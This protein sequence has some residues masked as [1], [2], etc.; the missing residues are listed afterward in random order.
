MTKPVDI[1]FVDD[2]EHIRVAVS[3][4]FELAD[5]NTKCFTSSI[6]LLQYVSRDF[7]GIV[8]SDIRMPD[9]DGVELLQKVTEIDY[10]LPVIL[11][12]GHGDV[13]LAVETMK[14]GAY[15]FIEKPFNPGHLVEIVKRA[16]SKRH[17]T[18]ENRVLKANFTNQDNLEVRL[19]GRT[20]VMT[21]LRKDV[22][23]I[24]SA[25]TD[26]LI[27]GDTGTGKEVVARALHDLGP[28]PDKPLVSINC[29]GL[30]LDQIESELFGHEQGAY[31][32]ALRARA[33]KFE[34]ARGG[35][36][37][38]DE[39]ENMP[40]QLQAKLLRVFEERT[41]TRL[42]SNEPIDLD[43]RFIAASKIDLENAVRQGNFREDLYY[44]LN[45]VVL[46]VPTL[47][48][49]REDIPMLFVQLA[50]DAARRHRRDFP[51]VP[52]SVLSAV[53]SKD[54]PGNVRELRN[55]AE[56]YVL[57]LEEPLL[58]EDGHIGCDNQFH[59]RVEEFEKTIITA[60]LAAQRGVLK[61]TH[62]ALG[63]SRKTLYEKMQKYG[64]NKE[65]YKPSDEDFHR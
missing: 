36:L 8:L 46:K 65:S 9:M 53:V 42:G 15:D 62:Q 51:E 38:L 5:F 34:H 37:F 64:L 24:A 28:N 32:G 16:L 47:A 59:D 56:R 13:S 39:V 58:I 54:W 61:A 48:E 21:A 11:V 20:D 2:E 25:D 33:G 57:G 18:L 43:L 29:A 22:R 35:T 30:P 12:T 1:L 63:L 3:Q 4:T 10:E 40:L 7:T 17:L 52:P 19:I 23:S 55:T 50:H 6:E 44:R 41:V 60:E 31:P 45:T 26:V 27:V 14:A 49:R